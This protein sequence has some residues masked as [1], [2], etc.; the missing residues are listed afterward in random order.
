MQVYLGKLESAS[1]LNLILG[2]IVWGIAILCLA[3][4]IFKMGVKRNESV[5][6]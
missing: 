5:G 6:L 4:R 1:I 2:G 3:I